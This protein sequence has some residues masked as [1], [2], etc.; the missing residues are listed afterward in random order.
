MTEGG[1][2]AAADITSSTATKGKALGSRVMSVRN[3]SHAARCTAPHGVG[4]HAEPPTTECAIRTG[5]VLDPET[6]RPSKVRE[7]LRRL[8]VPPKG[9]DT[10]G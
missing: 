7:L 2:S 1:N 6:P 3:V 10:K 8:G 9:S 5:K 4:S